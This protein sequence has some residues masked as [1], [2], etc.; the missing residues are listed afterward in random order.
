MDNLFARTFPSS[1]AFPESQAGRPL[2]RP[3]RGLLSVHSRYGLQTCQVA[4]ATFCTGGFSS[5]VAPTAAPIATG[6][7]E[8]APGR[9]FHPRWISAFP[10]RTEKFGLM[11]DMAALAVAANELTGQ[12][13]TP[14]SLSCN[15]FQFR[16]PFSKIV[17]NA[18]IAPPGE[19]LKSLVQF[20][21]HKL[22]TKILPIP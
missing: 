18:P 21:L 22:F 7:N 5:F 20:Q 14:L 2:H 4:Y 15:S 3:F 16:D 12:K 11:L 17:R 9:D 1:S 6:W 8:P 19:P 13:T 10:R